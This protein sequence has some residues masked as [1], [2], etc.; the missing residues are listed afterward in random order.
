MPIL[1][2]TRANTARPSN[3]RHLSPQPVRPDPSSAPSTDHHLSLPRARGLHTHHA[4]AGPCQTPQSSAFAGHGALRQRP[5]PASAARACEQGS[6]PSRG[7]QPATRFP[8]TF[9]EAS[10]PHPLGRQPPLEA[11]RD[12]QPNANC[13][14]RGSASG[15]S[16][17]PVAAFSCSRFATPATQLAPPGSPTSENTSPTASPKTGRLTT[18]F[19][20]RGSDSHK[21][22]QA[23]V[24]RSGS[25]QQQPPLR[26]AYHRPWYEPPF[27]NGSVV[28][29]GAVGSFPFNSFLSGVLSCVG[30]AVLAVCLRIQVNKENK[31]FK[32]L[33][34]ERAFA[35]FV[36]CNLVLHLVIMNFLG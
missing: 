22:C 26:A 23:V 21:V 20:T 3:R 35:D 34:P 9:A 27:F 25:Q 24:G 36:L 1:L 15:A 17:V 33:P 13:P 2:I 28:Y 5:S 4:N 6:T 11:I 30:T 8:F 16:R 31:E 32:D 29:M 19:A 10:R 18:S 12:A 7:S 14:S